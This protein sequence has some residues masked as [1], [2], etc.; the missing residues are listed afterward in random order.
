MPSQIIGCTTIVQRAPRAYRDQGRK[1]CTI[2]LFFFYPRAGLVV[3]T[4]FPVTKPFAE[5]DPRFGEQSEEK[6]GYFGKEYKFYSIG[7]F[8]FFQ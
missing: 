2:L 7:E 3:Y 5:W 8:S 1:F 6:R 4:R